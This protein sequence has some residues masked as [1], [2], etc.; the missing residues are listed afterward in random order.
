LNLELA[1][2]LIVGT[3]TLTLAFLGIRECLMKRAGR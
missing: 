2:T 1:F 3:L